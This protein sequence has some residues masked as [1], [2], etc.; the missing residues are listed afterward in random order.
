MDTFTVDGWD[1]ISNPNPWNFR[2]HSPSII[3]LALDS[4]G[5]KTRIENMSERWILNLALN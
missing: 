1:E 5:I 2:V 4:A 3:C